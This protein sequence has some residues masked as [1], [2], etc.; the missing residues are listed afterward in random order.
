M[1]D[2]VARRRTGSGQSSGLT[3]SASAGLY[4]A[5]RAIQAQAGN[6]VAVDGEQGNADMAD[7]RQ[8]SEQIL[9]RAQIE[10]EDFAPAGGSGLQH[11]INNRPDGEAPD[12]PTS[13]QAEAAAKAAGP[14]LC[15]RPVRGT[16]DAGR[17]EGGAAAPAARRWPIAGRARGR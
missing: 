14:D 16:A 2:D 9:G 5:H 8:V 11:I 10:L 15:S 12:Q 1:A 17:G 4:E 3:S 6:F 7:I 13:A